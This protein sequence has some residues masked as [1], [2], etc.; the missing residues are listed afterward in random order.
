MPLT[1]RTR[2]ISVQARNARRGA[3]SCRG[4][5][6]SLLRLSQPAATRLP[7]G[8][9]LSGWIER[10]ARVFTPAAFASGDAG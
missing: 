5:A 8:E 10:A 3:P 9:E 2:P 1:P 4:G 7:S 6:S